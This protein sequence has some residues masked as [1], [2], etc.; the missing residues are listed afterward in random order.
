MSIWE[1]NEFSKQN[2]INPKEEF[3]DRFPDVELRFSDG[4][5]NNARKMMDAMAEEMNVD[6]KQHFYANMENFADITVKVVGMVQN[7][8]DKARAAGVNITEFE[9]GVILA[10]YGQAIVLE[11]AWREGWE[12]R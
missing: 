7:L 2:R 8:I 6:V 1:Q 11:R 12:V 4:L 3:G 9:E 10:F 5:R